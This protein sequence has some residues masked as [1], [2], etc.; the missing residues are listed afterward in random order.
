M[1]KSILNTDRLKECRMALGLSQNE[2]AK[3]IG[4]SQ[5]TYLR[6]ESGLRNPS[7]QVVKEIARVFS[8]A[9]E[10]LTGVSD[11]SEPNSITIFH[12]EQPEMYNLIC[13]C[14]DMDL[15]QQKRMITYEKKIIK[16]H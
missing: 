15:A 4:V 13:I 3:R 10:Y 11:S 5:P 8:T 2:A 14:K 7:I 1:G 6:Y 16:P 9:P 12:N